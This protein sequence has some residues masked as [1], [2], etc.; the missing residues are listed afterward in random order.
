[1]EFQE[2]VQTLLWA[3]LGIVAV[4]LTGALSAVA[5]AGSAK[6][7]RFFNTADEQLA[8]LGNTPTGKYVYG[9]LMGLMGMV[10]D[11]DDKL[12]LQ[13]IDSPFFQPLRDRGVLTPALLSDVLSKAL[14]MGV[15]LFDGKAVGVSPAISQNNVTEAREISPEG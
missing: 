5:I 14:G 8:P 6:A 12:I 1:M 3:L 11:P 2:Y 7:V 15:Q 10:D 13:L 4:I 9:Q